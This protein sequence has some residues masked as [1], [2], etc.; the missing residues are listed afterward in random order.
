MPYCSNCRNFVPDGTTV[1]PHCGNQNSRATS[2]PQQPITQNQV[3]PASSSS[4]KKKK[5]DFKKLFF[6]DDRT[7]EFTKVDIDKNTNF[8]IL[9][10]LG[11]LII[12]PL[13]VARKSKYAMFHFCQGLLNIIAFVVYIFAL[14]IFDILPDILA[15]LLLLPAFCIAVIFPAFLIIG[16]VHVA[17][18]EAKTLPLYGRIDLMKAL[19]KN[20]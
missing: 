13:L 1:C 9:A 2:I 20:L 17:K 6:M 4:T 12:I 7:S 5:I 18:K 14:S 15:I 11:P 16:L 19:F 10:Y 8:A 3:P